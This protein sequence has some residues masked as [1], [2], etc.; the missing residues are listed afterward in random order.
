MVEK[1]LKT[2]KEQCPYVLRD[3]HTVQE[4]KKE[5]KKKKQIPLDYVTSCV[6]HQAG[7]DIMNRLR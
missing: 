5:C 4:I 2:C 7:V 1:M 3:E 6:R